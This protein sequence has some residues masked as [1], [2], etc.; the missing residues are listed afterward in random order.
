MNIKPQDI[1]L[2]V[3]L[4]GDSKFR[5]QTEYAS[6]LGMSQAEISTSLKRLSYAGLID[7]VLLLPYKENLVE[8]LVT[9]LSMFSLRSMRGSVRTVQLEGKV[10]SLYL[11]VSLVSP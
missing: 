5:K 4:L 2:A 8:F 10:L 1:L 3:H 6:E 9:V 11:L 7:K